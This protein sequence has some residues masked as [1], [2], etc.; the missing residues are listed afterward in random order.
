MLDTSRAAVA[1]KGVSIRPATREP[2]RPGE[3][4][5]AVISA[6]GLERRAGWS[7]PHKTFRPINLERRARFARFDAP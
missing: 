5:T 3:P 4:Q 7:L 2:E 1:G 6:F